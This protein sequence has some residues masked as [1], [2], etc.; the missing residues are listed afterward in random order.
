MMFKIHISNMVL[1]IWLNKILF[2]FGY[3]TPLYL[4]VEQGCIDIVNI[5]VNYRKIDVNIGL[6]LNHIFV[7]NLHI[8]LLNVIFMNQFN[9]IS[10]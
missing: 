10:T 7:W 6:I 1:K 4:A 2:Y 8:R 5:L 9:K 3:K